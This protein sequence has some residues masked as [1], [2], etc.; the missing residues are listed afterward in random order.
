MAGMNEDDGL[1]HEIL[2]AELRTNW[3]LIDCRKLSPNDDA[4]F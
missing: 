2:F 1:P 4:D 3:F